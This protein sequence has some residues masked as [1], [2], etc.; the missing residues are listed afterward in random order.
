MTDEERER[1]DFIE[2]YAP[3]YKKM[4]HH[5]MLQIPDEPWRVDASWRDAG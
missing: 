2:K 3:W 1:A 4:E 5:P